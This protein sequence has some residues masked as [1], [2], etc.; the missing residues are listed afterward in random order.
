MSL[1]RFFTALDTTKQAFHAKL[2]RQMARNGALAQLELVVREVRKDHPGMNMRDLHR[3]INPD[4][5]GR[6]AFE[7]YFIGMG[8]GVQVKKVFRGTTDSSGVVRFD[9]LVEGFE[10]DGVNQIWVS[11]IT[12][13]RIGDCFYYLTFVMDLFSRLIVGH[14]VSRSLRTQHT[15]IPALRRGLRAR[16]TNLDGLIFHSDGGGQ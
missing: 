5:I 7:T 13:Y 2:D 1:N 10:L 4:F 3:V 14:Q 15:T 6:D 12:Y 16:A 8:Y 9:N 11:D